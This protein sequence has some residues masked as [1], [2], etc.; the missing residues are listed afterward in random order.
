MRWAP[1]ARRLA[2]I[3]SDALFM[4]VVDVD[5]RTSRTV[6]VLPARHLGELDA[7][8]LFS[9]A[10]SPDGRFLAAGSSSEFACDEDSTGPCY[11]Q[12]Y[13][14]V[15]SVAAVGRLAHVDDGLDDASILGWRT[16]LP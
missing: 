13:W 8:Y 3:D 15:D 7:E 11:D 5:R 2:L 9:L 16:T 12:A 6:F 1:D 10:W 4:R 14:I